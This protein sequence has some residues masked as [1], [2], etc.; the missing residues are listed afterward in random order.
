MK[1]IFVVLEGLDGS[2]TSTQA[3]LLCE[4]LRMRYGKRVRVTSEPSSG[5]VGQMIRS[6][7]SGRL[8]FSNTQ[9]V[10]DRQMAYLFAADRHDHLY[11]DTDGVF[12]LIADGYFVIS[13]R[14]FF[15][16][17]AYHCV[18]PEE[19][20]FIHALNQSFPNP[21]A[22]IYLDIDVETSIAR[23]SERNHLD[24]YENPE[25]L[26]I[27]KANYSAIFSQYAGSFKILNGHLP[28]KELADS[29]LSFVREVSRD[30]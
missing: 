9:A 6:S 17:Y 24:L 23:L 4:Q 18:N 16:S 14:Y 27:V 26:R 30:G 15:S 7:M 12:K 25:K 20:R 5:P 22:T 2:G 10:F 1:P 11:N 8:R 19:F 3:R 21:D 29:C 28:E 13:T